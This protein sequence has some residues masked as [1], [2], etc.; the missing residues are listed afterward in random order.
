LRRAALAWLPLL[1]FDEV[2]V[3]VVGDREMRALNKRWRGKE[4]TTDVLS[5]PSG[6]ERGFLGD[7]IISI[8]TARKQAAAGGWSLSRELRRLLAHGMLHCAG[9]DHETEQDAAKMA[10]AE[11][12]L[13][14]EEGMVG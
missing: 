8:E 14:G 9:H 2:S 5:F 4:Q 10:R 13:L 7:V 3:A 6:D 12:K 11:R 1:R